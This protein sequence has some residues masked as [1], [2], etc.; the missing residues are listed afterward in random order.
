MASSSIA[1]ITF[2]TTIMH[3]EVS[4]VLLKN[5]TVKG[6]NVMKAQSVG[7]LL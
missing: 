7:V 2:P 1:D 4:A 6:I 3:V 5:V